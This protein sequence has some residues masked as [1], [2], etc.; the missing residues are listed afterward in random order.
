[1]EELTESPI[2]ACSASTKSLLT[3]IL[4]RKRKLDEHDDPNQQHHQRHPRTVDQ[5]TRLG[6]GSDSLRCRILG[7]VYLLDGGC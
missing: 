1:M 3:A 7:P 2:E 6:A 4:P 5:R